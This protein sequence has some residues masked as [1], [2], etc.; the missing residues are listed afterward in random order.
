MV[1]CMWA[2]LAYQSQL[3]KRMVH[4]GLRLGVSLTQRAVLG[5]AKD[6]RPEYWRR[7]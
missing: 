7:R 3:D 2:S 1:R 4:G 6:R 5:R